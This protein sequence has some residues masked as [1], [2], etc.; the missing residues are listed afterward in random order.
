MGGD[1]V[2]V[3]DLGVNPMGFEQVVA[4]VLY[5]LGG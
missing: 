3:R 4:F 1:I 5:C 2:V